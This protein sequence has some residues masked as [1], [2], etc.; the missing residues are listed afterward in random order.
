MRGRGPDREVQVH[1]L[2]FQKLCTTDRERYYEMYNF[3]QFASFPPTSCMSF[4][5][6][7]FSF[8]SIFITL[9]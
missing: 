3:Q 6:E 5:A 9:F 4:G 2:D 7:I 8:Y 1:V